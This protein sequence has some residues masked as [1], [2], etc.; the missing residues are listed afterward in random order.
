MKNFYSRLFRRISGPSKQAEENR[1]ANQALEP[2]LPRGPLNGQRLGAL[3]RFRLGRSSY[4]FSGCE[5]IA[6]YNACRLLGRTHTLSQ[7]GYRC[8]CLSLPMLWGFWGSDP[9]AL[10]KLMEA[11][12]LKWERLESLARAE[13]A[14]DGVFILSFWNRAGN[15]FHGIHTVAVRRREG[16]CWVYNRY[17]NSTEAVGYPSL[18]QAID[19][20]D[21][22]TAYRVK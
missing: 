20:G 9:Y 22:L 5:V 18:E 12:G 10:W 6:V 21:F 4:G 8:E 16:R 19:K 7:V 11:C 2:M 13:Q 14:G 1:R 15:P 17:N 3:G